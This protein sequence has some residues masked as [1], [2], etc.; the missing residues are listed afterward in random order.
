M[1]N[2]H[3]T[4]SL[5]YLGINTYKEPIIYMREDCHICKSEGFYAQARV[6]VA[7]N[8]RSI[9]ATVNTIETDLLRHN[10]ASLSDYAWDLLAAKNGDQVSI[11]HPKPLDS[12]SYIRSKVYGNELKTGET[13]QIID[14]LISGQL[15]DI[16]I[17]MF[18]AA[19]AGD[20]LSKKEILDLTS[21]MI[22]SGQRITWP[23]SLVVDKHCIGGL[24]GNRTTPIVVS[25][26]AAFGLMIPKTSSRAITSPAGTADTMEVFTSV[27]LDLP[28]MR[29]VVE[30]ENGCLVWGGSM[31]LS[32]ADDLLIRIERTADLDSE[33]QMI[34]SILSKKIAAGSTH[35][36]I[37]MPIGTTA[38][39][40]SIEHGKLLKSSLESVAQEFGIETKIMITDGS[41]PI[42]RGIGPALEAVDVWAVLQCDK[43]A[44]QNLRERALLLA[45]Q[46][47]EFSPGVLPGQGINIA[48]AILDSG[49]ALAKFEAICMAQ[50][51]LH[52]IPKAAFSHTVE[53][54]VSGTIINIDN[55]HIAR[56][57]KL[58][59]AP[60]AKVAGVEL[61]VTLN[62]IVRK[63]QP[64]FKIA[65]ETKGQLH[66]A[67]DFLKQGHDIFQIEVSS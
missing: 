6:R 7:L 58:A 47:L 62:T 54:T 60:Q 37:D 40:R 8:K 49:K 43:H 38:K 61:L 57:A 10:E 13:K 26:V 45:G 63:S 42:G 22:D 15:S 39:V 55:R 34:A 5:K 24:P 20:K 21:A 18:I 9:I 50:G 23:S 29:K 46:V 14:D 56:V 48:T 59:G 2:R 33:G 27:N 65:A 41:Q 12:L 28:A 4:L 3:S 66:Y 67:L 51:G 25:I 36:V 53:S 1:R 35:L 16:N 30:Q 11:T 44:P 52:D 64:L 17:A 32:P 31:S 19:S